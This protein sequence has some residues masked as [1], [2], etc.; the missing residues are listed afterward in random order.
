MVEP[1]HTERYRVRPG[2]HVDLRGWDP[3][4][5]S[6]FD[7]D[8]SAVATEMAKLR[9]R[10]DELQEMLFIEDRRSLLIVLQGMDTAGKDGTIRKVFE[11]VNPAGVRVA[12]FRE[13]GPEEL[14]HDFLWRV[15]KQVPAKGELV[16]F[17]R[18]HYE[19]VLIEEVH[20]IIDEKTCHQRYKMINDFERLL[21]EGGTTILKF[22]LNIDSDEQKKRLEERLAD[23]NK[24]WKFSSSDLPERRLWP[25][26]MKAYEHVLEKT[27]TDWAPWYAVPSNHKWYRDL[28][29]ARVIVKT[30]EKFDMKYP[31]GPK[32]IKSLT[33]K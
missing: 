21:S 25:R 17:N 12:H 18:S 33:V 14:A 13:P 7:G 1:P 26:Y 2:Q 10:L 3:N 11:G 19:S 23:P 15:H 5:T 31:P 28:V 27:S 20:K 6:G 8:E 30:M 24:R 29:V 16:I 9:A 22:Y 32:D 4:D